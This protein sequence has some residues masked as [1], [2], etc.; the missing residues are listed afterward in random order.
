METLIMKP[1]DNSIE[2]AA[3][4]LRQGEVVA[5]P[6]ET[7]Y[8]LAANA[9]STDAVNKIYEAKGR[10]SDNPLIVHIAEA[11]MMEKLCCDIPK[12]AYVLSEKFWPGSL[13]MVL[14]KRKLIPDI[15]SGGLDTV[16]VRMPDNEHTLDIIKK[17]G[18]PLAAPSANLSGMP[19]PTAAVHVFE[20]MKGKIPLIIDGGRC[21][22]G[23]ESTV[24]SFIENGVSIL[25][26][27]AVTAEMLSD[28][29]NVKI[30]DFV[31]NQANSGVKPISPG[32]KYK[33]YSPNAKVFLVE[34]D[35]F[36]FKNYVLKHNGEK[37]CAIIKQENLDGINFY[38]Y[39]DDDKQQAA[40]IF[41]LLRLADKDGMEK[42][43]IHAPK[44]DGL[45][46]AVYNRLIRAAGFDII[47][48]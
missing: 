25:R 5:V 29:C 8:G 14:N 43:Y 12:L 33:H 16:G 40:K 44:K 34:A 18:I 31:L 41:A 46:L 27:G 21:R 10:P 32:V 20:D 4:L 39:G 11:S 2:L 15:T 42:I 3:K 23:V 37:V 9:L 30:D 24:I 47:K 28:F 26:P 38:S 17:A 13:T 22:V 36:H 48:L 6:T 35:D 45:A 19:S 7:V 1:S